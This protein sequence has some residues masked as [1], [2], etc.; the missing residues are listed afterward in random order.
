MLDLKFIRNHPESVR[1]GALAKNRPIDLDQ[2]LRLDDEKRQLQSHLENG[3]HQKNQLTRQIHRYKQTGEPFDKLL[4]DIHSLN[5]TIKDHQIKIRQLDQ[6]LNDLL[7]KIPNLPHPS[8]PAGTTAAD[9]VIIKEWGES[10]QVDFP[11]KPHWEL[12]QR[13][14][15]LDFESGSQL[16]GPFFI[17]FKG[18]GAQL[19]RA[20]INFMLDLHIQTHSYLEVSPPYLAK[21]ESLVGTG[22][23]PLMEQE[24]YRLERDDLFLIPTA[25][26]PLTNLHRDEIL[27]A[28]QLPLKYVAATPCFRREAGTYGRETRGLIRIHQ[29]DK[30]ELVQIVEP[31]QAEEALEM[32]RQEAEQVLQL[33]ELPYRVSLLCAGELSFAA[34]KSYDLEV[35]A[36]AIQRN[37]EVST[38]SHFGDFQARRINLRYR[39]ARGEKLCYV[40]TLNASGL[41]LPRTMIAILENYQ[42][43]EGTVMVPKVLQK[44]LG[45]AVIKSR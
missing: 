13:L 32:L 2:F 42:T 1:Q 12:G 4:S 45:T 31:E 19:E 38:C 33:L 11:L 34:A 43:E 21:R 18:W 14:G 27:S 44:Y 36:A 37:L 6:Q 35:W 8:V 10:I 22:Q 39:P 9:N 26:V 41:A 28:E 17:N 20:L 15:I 29:F 40:H 30:V 23:L 24:M 3:L 5:Q 7:L 16:A 25:E